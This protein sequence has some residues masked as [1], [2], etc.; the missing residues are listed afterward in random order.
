MIS[1]S[2]SKS[3]YTSLPLPPGVKTTPVVAQLT[4]PQNPWECQYDLL[5]EIR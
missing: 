1:D 2:K 5:I 3:I 4:M